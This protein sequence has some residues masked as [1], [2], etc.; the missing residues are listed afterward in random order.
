MLDT[1]EVR[2]TLNAVIEYVKTQLG[3]ERIS[4]LDMPCGD[5]VWMK[6][7]LTNRTDVYYTG[8]DIV[9]SLIAHHSKMYSEEHQN[10]KFKNHDIVKDPLLPGTTNHS[11]QFLCL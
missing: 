1:V 9:G 10:W 6:H 4:I 7:Y 2:K 3:K 8:M 5:L 11:S